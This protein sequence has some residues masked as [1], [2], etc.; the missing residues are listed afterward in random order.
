MNFEGRDKNKKLPAEHEN[1][2]WNE[3]CDISPIFD[4][5]HFIPGGIWGK[6]S[7]FFNVAFIQKLSC[8]KKSFFEAFDLF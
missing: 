2:P 5:K 3:D 7:Q 1:E 4:K 8:K 6:I